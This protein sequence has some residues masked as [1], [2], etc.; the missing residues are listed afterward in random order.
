[1][2]VI[3]IKPNVGKGAKVVWETV[4]TV[5]DRVAWEFES[6]SE[7]GTTKQNTGIVKR[8]EFNVQ[9]DVT[10]HVDRAARCFGEK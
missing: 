8:R 6:E 2:T 9:G 7:P 4:P 10:L 1:M 3:K 5:G